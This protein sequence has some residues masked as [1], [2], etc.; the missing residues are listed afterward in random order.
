VL[1]GLSVTPQHLYRVNGAGLVSADSEAHACEVWARDVGPALT[2]EQIP[3]ARAIRHCRNG[4][5]ETHTADV[6]AIFY[7]GRVV[8]S[9]VDC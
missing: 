1:R 9:E 3:D 2:I 7:P 5:Y 4:R 6:W 8:G